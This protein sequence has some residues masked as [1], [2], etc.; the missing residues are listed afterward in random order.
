MH[1]SGVNGWKKRG[2]V[3]ASLLIAVIVGVTLAGPSVAK[4]V[5]HH[6]DEA[7]F[8]NYVNTYVG[9][10]RSSN[11]PRGHLRDSA[12][13][14]RHPGLILEEGDRAC[15]WLADQRSA[16]DVDPSGRSTVDYM[17]RRY[18]RGTQDER[19][20]ELSSMGRSRVVAG[21]WA[22]LCS[23]DRDDHT[24]PEARYED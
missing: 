20:A 22:Y 23:R 6:R 7:A 4:R 14:K 9:G 8:S 24:A 16:P 5:M 2:L 13:A 11:D 17:S 3:A 12:W 21:A 1:G 15:R 19:I 10:W 18:L